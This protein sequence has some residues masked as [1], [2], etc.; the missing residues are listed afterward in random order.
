VA[1]SH[2]VAASRL[3]GSYRLIS[4]KTCHRGGYGQ[5]RVHSLKSGPAQQAIS[6]RCVTLGSVLRCAQR[7]RLWLRSEEAL[8]LCCGAQLGRCLQEAQHRID[9]STAD[10]LSGEPLRNYICRHRML[11]GRVTVQSISSASISAS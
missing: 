8:H 4:V 11:S 10:A 5:Y 7:R 2:K 3:G 1:L 9:R 6:T